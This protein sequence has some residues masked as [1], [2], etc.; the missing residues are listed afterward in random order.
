MACAEVL[1]AAERGGKQASGVFWGIGIGM[2]FKLLTGGLKLVHSKFLLPLG[3]K[4]NIAIS[5]SPALMG[6]GY[7]LGIRIASVM[8][9]GGALSALVI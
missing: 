2:F 3:F 8:V 4:A 1:V 6:V 9:A 5:V 7:I